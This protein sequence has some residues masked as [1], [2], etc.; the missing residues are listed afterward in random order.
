[1]KS[2]TVTRLCNSLATRLCN[3]KYHEILLIQTIILVLSMDLSTLRKI[4]NYFHAVV[5]IITYYHYDRLHKKESRKKERNLYNKNKCWLTKS[6]TVTRLC[7]SLLLIRTIILVLSMAVSTLRTNYNHFHTVV[8]I[9]TYY[10]YDR[11]HTKKRE[12]KRKNL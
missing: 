4:Y 7:N 10:H 11:L 12:T 3:L 6:V 8:N 1:M 9:I 5:N 2:I